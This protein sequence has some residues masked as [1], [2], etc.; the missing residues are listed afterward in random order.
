MPEILKPVVK[1]VATLAI[2]NDTTHLV[3]EKDFRAIAGYKEEEVVELERASVGYVV[4]TVK[5]KEKVVNRSFSSQAEAD[6]FIALLG[7]KK[8]TWWLWT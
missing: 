7:T 6:K 1:P 3:S 2:S 5:G 8:V 4:A